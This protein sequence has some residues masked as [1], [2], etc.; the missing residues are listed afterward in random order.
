MKYIS[1]KNQSPAVDLRTAVLSSLPPDN[2]LYLPEK[3]PKLSPA[4]L[5]QLHQLSFPDIAY[6]IALRMLGEDMPLE[7]LNTIIDE[8][9]NFPVILKK[10]GSTLYCLELFHGPTLAFKDFAARFM[11][12]V[13]G[14]FCFAG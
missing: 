14:I 6:E 8:A 2:G 10:L 1:T 3:L 13:I 12:R 7:V 11:A 5:V 4:L 9:F